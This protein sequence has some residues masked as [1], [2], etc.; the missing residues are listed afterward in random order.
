MVHEKQ[1]AIEIFDQGI[2]LYNESKFDEAIEKCKIARGIFEKLNVEEYVAYTEILIGKALQDLGNDNKALKHYEIGKQ[3][4]IKLGVKKEVGAVEM[5]IGVALDNLGRSGEALKHYETAKSIYENFGGKED[6]AD[7]ETNIGKVFFNIGQKQQALKHYETAKSIYL[8]LGVK[9]KVAMIEMNIAST[10]NEIAKPQQASKHYEIAKTFIEKFGTEENLAD[11]E[12]NIGV[13]LQKRGEAKEALKHFKIAKTIYEKFKMEK[14]IAGIELNVGMTLCDLGIFNEV[15]KHYEIAKT[16]YE[17]FGME[18]KV[19]L[20][21]NNIAVVLIKMGRHKEALKHYETAKTIFDKLGMEDNVASTELNIGAVLQTM[22]QTKEALKHY[23]TAKLIFDKLGM[24]DKV[25]TIEVNIGAVLTMS[26]TKEALKHYETAKLIFDKLGIKKEAAL[27]KVNIAISLAN[28]GLIN[29]ALKHL[30]EALLVFEEFGFCMEQ[31]KVQESIAEL[32]IAS[33]D[34]DGA[35]RNLDKSFNLM[36]RVRIGVKSPELRKSLKEQYLSVSELLCFVHLSLAEKTGDLQHVEAALNNIELAKCSLIAEALEL[37]GAGV[38]CP[39]MEKLVEE[40]NRLLKVAMESGEKFNNLAELSG[41]GQITRAEFRSS[42][43]ALEQKYDDAQNRIEEIESE[44]LIKC[45]DYGSSPVLRSYNVL[46]RAKEV[47]PRDE[48]WNILEFAILSASNRLAVFLVD[49]DGSIQYAMQDIDFDKIK[50]LAL[51]CQGVAKKVRES[52]YEEANKELAVLSKEL[53]AAL[54][55]TEI[56]KNLEDRNVKYLLIVPHKFLHLV[57]FELLFDGDEY[58]GLKYA[59]SVN[60][61]LDLAR[62]SV[63]KREKRSTELKEDLSFLF[64][65][66][67]LMDLGGADKEVNDVCNLLRAQKVEFQVLEHEKVTQ[68]AFI[69]TVGKSPFGILHYAGHALFMGKDPDLSHLNLHTDKECPACSGNV[70]ES[71]LCE[72]FT[73]TEVIHKVKFKGTP[74]VYL[75]AC[76]T[77][78]AEVELGDEMFGLVRG[79]MYAGATSLVLSRWLVSDASAPNLAKEFYSQLL[80]GESVGVA[81]REARQE[82]F[83]DKGFAF[84]DW[85]TFSVNGDPFR[86]VV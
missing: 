58:W 21:E 8:K 65:K 54:I 56:G 14:G 5:S 86:K 31:S 35:L 49:R 45:A 22:S 9:R 59:I 19:A 30:E 24:E 34:F 82:V 13:S 73:A 37:G 61:S 17:K 20:I 11:V 29:V 64:V 44:I 66:N 16:I 74:I 38:P 80:I 48:K 84:T 85:A 55:P 32:L 10:L 1:R 15:F 36:E 83:K 51:R 26:Q 2:G 40:K 79:F 81:L 63:E 47:F 43:S 42:T 57:P 18:H 77:G 68:P 4:Y 72:P 50:G 75:S 69:E 70:K 76:E 53:Y 33:G 41:K 62:M 6:L 39:E 46:K 3:I 71:H 23:E 27:I 60:F 7:I 25:A 67:P 52:R 12:R 78:I 28:I